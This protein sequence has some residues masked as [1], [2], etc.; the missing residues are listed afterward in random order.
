M[1]E[2]KRRRYSDEERAACLAALQANAG[3]VAKTARECGVPRDTLRSWLAGAKVV[4]GGESDS[5]PEKKPAAVRAAEML[6]VAKRTLEQ[7]L[8]RFARR[9]VRHALGRLKDLSAKDAMIA[10]GVAIDK[11]LLLR[12]QPPAEP[13]EAEPVREIVVR[14]REEAQAILALAE[15]GRLPPPAA[16]RGAQ[17][18]GT[19][20]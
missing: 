11:A 9:G 16:V 4:N 10:V 2:R 5:P 18:K 19:I 7:E 8:E 20:A 12:G 17:E 13:E 1:K 14:T 3:N 6:P 15:A